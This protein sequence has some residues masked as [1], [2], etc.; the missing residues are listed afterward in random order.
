MKRARVVESDSDNENE[1]KIEFTPSTVRVYAC[2]YCGGRHP[3]NFCPKKQGDEQQQ[4]EHKARLIG[5]LKKGS[6]KGKMSFEVKLGSNFTYS[7]TCEMGIGDFARFESEMKTTDKTGFMQ[8]TAKLDK[9]G[10]TRAQI[11]EAKKRELEA[12]LEARRL[13]DEARLEAELDSEPEDLVPK[14]QDAEFEVTS[15]ACRM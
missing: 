13:R 9:K 2:S 12:A 15:P 1:C 6:L 4:R 7:A 10:Q 8:E 5:L 14:S 3:C 11:K